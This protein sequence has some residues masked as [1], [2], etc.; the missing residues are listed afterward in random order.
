MVSRYRTRLWVQALED[1]RTPATFT[2]N[3]TADAGA[4]SLRQAITDSNGA[5][6]ADSI[7]FD[8][9]VFSTSQTVSLLSVLPTISDDV[10]IVGTGSGK[11]TVT[12]NVAAT[13]FRLLNVSNASKL[14]TVSVTGV[15]FTN[16]SLVTSGS[17]QTDNGGGINI[18][19]EDVTLNDVVVSNCTSNQQGGGIAVREG[20][21]LTMINCTVSGNTATGAVGGDPLNP[22]FSGV[23]G[24]VYFTQD[25][26]LTMIGCTVSGNQAKYRGAGVYLFADT[27]ATATIRNSTISGNK[28]TS[29]YS[30]GYLFTPDSGGAGIAVNTNPLNQ[31]TATV[32]IQNSTIYQNT[33]PNTGSG[34]GISAMGKSTIVIDSSVVSGNVTTTG[35]DINSVKQIT[36]NT[37]AIGVNSGFTFTG[38]NNLTF[39][40]NLKLGALASNGGP[41]MTHMPAFDLSV[42]GNNSPLIDAGSNPAA[43]AGDQRVYARTYDNSI[44]TNKVSAVDIGAAEAQPAG[45][46]TALGT[47]P[48]VTAAGGTSHTITVTFADD[49]A[50]KVNTLSTGDVTVT[51][52]AGYNATATFVSVDINTDGTPRIVTYTITPPGGTWNAADAGTYTINIVGSQVTDTSGLAVSAGPA[53][54]FKV[55]LPRTLVVTNKNDSGPGSLRQ[56]IIDANNLAPSQD[57]ITFSSFFNTAQK[58]SL[59]SGPLSITD[60]VKITGP[61]ANLLTIDAGGASRHMVIDGAGVLN[62]EIT[63]MI[64][65]AGHTTGYF[66]SERGGSI[67][68]NGENVVMDDVIMNLNTVDAAYGGAIHLA[69]QASLVFKNGQFTGNAAGHKSDGSGGYIGGAG[70]AIS[71]ISSGASI[72]LTNT[73]FSTNSSDFFGGAIYCIGGGTVNI[74]GCTFANNKNSM[75]DDPLQTGGGAINMGNGGSS[76]QLTIT[77]STFSNN[78]SLGHGGALLINGAAESSG[79]L[80]QNSTFA[81]NKAETAAYGVGGAMLIGNLGTSYVTI[82]NST[83]AY[84]QARSGGG[85]FIGN[86]DTHVNLK[87]TIVSQNSASIDPA[88]VDIDGALYAEY[89][90]IGISDGAG[91]DAASHDNIVGSTGTQGADPLFGSFDYNG[92]PTQNLPLNAGSPAIDAGDNAASL[93][94][95]QRG[96]GYPR[97]GGAK[98]DIGAYESVVVVPPSVASIQIADGSAQRSTIRSITV[99]FSTLVSLGGGTP[100]QAFKLERTGPGTPMNTVGLTADLSGSTGTQTICKLTFDGPLT[101]GAGSLIDGLYTLTVFATAVVDGASQVMAADN[102]SDLH[103]LFGDVNGDKSVSGSDFN[104]FRSAFGGS[105][106][107]FDFDGDGAVSSSDFN[108]FRE[109]FGASL[110]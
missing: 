34:G 48:D 36:L 17:Q 106:A 97:V 35:S 87:S 95:D 101:E 102:L 71:S 74:D 28:T 33:A 1:R 54:T 2:V 109:R 62:V 55:L 25:G 7:V 82:Q 67:N 72:V 38:S 49:T 99:T 80:I 104:L 88:V 9:G 76:G 15:R 8:A 77:N 103:R 22:G 40:L 18:G 26:N 31:S 24:G 45:V 70:G 90:L 59:S 68:I 27:L 79:H 14:L 47:A 60:S 20:G 52:P 96:V 73:V 39:G 44:V 43:L 91:L 11:V 93:L 94:Y 12:R 64:L 66:V 63:G 84:N 108:R 56:A 58:I 37:S 100:E 5:A 86:N 19:S 53:G 85:L 42:A 6:G 3:T 10:A 61:G 41:T 83:I 98:A 57:V 29:I 13:D 89:S 50:I 32:T 78:Q 16:G 30:G 69:G 46:P 23:G 4:G 105:A 75:Y 107:E 51:G 21:R 81:F 92:G 110:P 65:T